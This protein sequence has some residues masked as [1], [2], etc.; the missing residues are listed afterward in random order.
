MRLLCMEPCVLGLWDW[1]AHSQHTKSQPIISGLRRA[2]MKP[3][4]TPATRAARRHLSAIL[5]EHGLA[6]MGV[7]S[8]CALEALKCVP[9]YMDGNGRPLRCVPCAQD[10]CTSPERGRYYRLCLRAPIRTNFNEPWR[11]GICS[12]DGTSCEPYVRHHHDWPYAK[13]WAAYM[14]PHVNPSAICSL[15]SSIVSFSIL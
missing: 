14:P 6:M 13:R 7:A 1:E 10:G 15:L 12:D 5:S 3:T 8:A 11:L 2:S 4:W 9:T